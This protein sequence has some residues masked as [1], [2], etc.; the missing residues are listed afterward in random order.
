MRAPSTVAKSSSTSGD[1]DGEDFSESGVST[2]VSFGGTDNFSQNRG[3]YLTDIASV[4]FVL[5]SFG[6]PFLR[7]P[8]ALLAEELAQNADSFVDMLLL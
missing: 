6:S 5:G 7:C 4:A 1:M 2:G 8:P 3:V